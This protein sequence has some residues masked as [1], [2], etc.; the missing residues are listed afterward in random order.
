MK[1]QDTFGR[2]ISMNKPKRKKQPLALNII[3]L[4]AIFAVLFL[5][6]GLLN[7]VD[8]F[9][10]Y[11]YCVTSILFVIIG[12]PIARRLL[13][14]TLDGSIAYSLAIG[15]LGSSLFTFL[16][17]YMGIPAFS[18]LGVRTI[19]VG[20]SILGLISILYTRYRNLNNKKTGT[21]K[22][23]TLEFSQLKLHSHNSRNFRITNTLLTALLFLAA[24]L[25][26]TYVRSFKPEAY[27]LEKFMD[28]GFMT[29]MWR[30]DTLPAQDMWLAGNSINYYYFGQYVFTFIAKFTGVHPSHSY[31]L[32][33]AM[34]FALTFVLAYALVRDALY[35]RNIMS[36]REKLDYVKQDLSDE[37]E[38]V[39]DSKNAQNHS[40]FKDQSVPNL[41][42][43]LA[44]FLLTLGGN[45]HSFFY[46]PDN[47]GYGFIKYLNKLRFNVGD[48]YNY[49]FSDSTRFIGHNPDVGDLTI[50]EFPFYSYLVA[51]LH[52]HMI[53]LSFVLLFLAILLGFIASYSE[54]IEASKT[55]LF[56]VDKNPYI[57]TMAILLGIFTMTNYWD[58]AIYLVVVTI[59]L[60]ALYSYGQKDSGSIKGFLLFLFQMGS[61]IVIFLFISEPF[62]QIVGFTGIYFIS[63]YIYNEAP[64]AWSK[65]GLST[66]FIFVISHIIALPFNLNISSMPKEIGLVDRHSSLFQLFIV[67]AFHILMAIIFI[68]YF[69]GENYSRFEYNLKEKKQG[70]LSALATVNRIDLFMII[71]TLSALGLILMPELIYVKDIY[72]ENYQRTNTM[73]KFTYQSFSLLSLVAAYTTGISFSKILKPHPI[74]DD[75]VH[76][77]GDKSIELNMPQR[78]SGDKSSSRKN[79]WDWKHI[80]LT[81]GLLVL[82]IVP[83][84]YI[85]SIEQWY[86][87][88]NIERSEGLEATS[89]YARLTADDFEGNTH[90]LAD[91]L[92]LIG[93]LNRTEN[94]QVNIVEA[95]GSSYS[96]YAA[97]SAYTGLP[98]VLG[99][100]T[101]QWLWRTESSDES[102]YFTIVYPLQEK[103]T[104]FYDGENFEVMVDFV[105]EFEIKYIIVGELE[106]IK[107]PS[108]NETSL[109]YLGDVVYRYNDDY[110]IQVDLSGMH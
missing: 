46:N 1:T 77:E 45:S 65:T 21:V 34:S 4:I 96:D 61:Q 25:F 16:I 39:L 97:V 76:E 27:G 109:Q 106:R 84:S 24:F 79:H 38:Y 55:S 105:E 53:N 99:W 57:W 90:S 12:Y 20:L 98:T 69:I 94:E 107:Y 89:Y 19:V 56:K 26:W 14:F 86:G 88:L 51:D 40:R 48:I 68:T 67:W 93:Y 102:A 59:S 87:E 13:S 31:N 30:T 6:T 8:L 37:D 54:K 41:V 82:F 104:S 71:L 72:G 60:F 85:D 74:D 52:A 62:W 64:S 36:R 91:R 23:K 2:N 50:H 43:I 110:I 11:F 9:N 108:I 3:L 70:F 58:F 49:F 92:N 10:F 28:Y 80:A 75:D 63:A 83:F 33:I 17:S 42:G 32:S 35:L 18:I 78:F 7:Q 101:H 95:H 47:L 103:L 73:F 15:L 22:S 66:A 100:E 5:A 29:S 81:A 44:A